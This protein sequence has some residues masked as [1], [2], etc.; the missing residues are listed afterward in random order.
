MQ[1]RKAKNTAVGPQLPELVRLTQGSSP[2]QSGHGGLL[3]LLGNELTAKGWRQRASN[4][5]QV[6]PAELERAAQCS[7]RVPWRPQS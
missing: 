2:S 3:S 7:L 5:D 4:A 6:N 1:P